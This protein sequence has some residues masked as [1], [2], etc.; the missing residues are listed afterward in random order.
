MATAA[1]PYS[2]P[3]SDKKPIKRRHPKTS[4]KENFTKNQHS[5]TSPTNTV[6]Q[7]KG[8][9]QPNGF[10]T[11]QAPIK[12]WI[13]GVSTPTTRPMLILSE[14]KYEEVE[15]SIL[16]YPTSDKKKRKTSKIQKTY[17]ALASSALSG[18]VIAIPGV[19]WVIASKI[20]YF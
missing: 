14:Q 3:V 9:Y 7:L 15:D 18:V 1:S 8:I 11:R 6:K 17:N 10:P 16:F 5:T 2:I 13:P 20:G 12:P 4:E 19:C